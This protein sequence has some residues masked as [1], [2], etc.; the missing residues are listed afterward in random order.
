MNSQAPAITPAL[1]N[2][3]ETL[4]ERIRTVSVAY[5]VSPDDLEREVSQSLAR[6]VTNKARIK[7]RI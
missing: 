2:I 4:T 7:S 6:R 5:G 3:L 1:I